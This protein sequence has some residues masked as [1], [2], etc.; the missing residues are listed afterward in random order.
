MSQVLK[1]AEIKALTARNADLAKQVEELKKALTK[2]SASPAAQVP[3]EWVALL[4]SQT[5]FPPVLVVLIALFS[6]LVGLLF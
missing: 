6:F 5:G 4:N 1:D 2:A 3:P